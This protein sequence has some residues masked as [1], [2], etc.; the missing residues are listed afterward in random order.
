MRKGKKYSD[1]RGEDAG[2]K[3]RDVGIMVYG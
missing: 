3:G 1:E 2:C